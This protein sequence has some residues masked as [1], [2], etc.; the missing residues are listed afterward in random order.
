MRFFF[1]YLIILACFSQASAQDTAS[2][3]KADPAPFAELKKAFTAGSAKANREYKEEETV[4]Q[5][6]RVLEITRKLNQQ[7]KLLLKK[8][9]DTN[10]LHTFLD[11][12]RQSLDIVKEGIWVNAGTHQTQRNLA[13]SSAILVELST[14]IAQRKKLVDDYLEKLATIKVRIDSMGTDP[15]IYA[16]PSDSATLLKFVQRIYVA[17][18][19]ISPVDTAMN[20]TITSL[21]ALQLKTDLLEFEIRSAQEDIE[22]YSLELSQNTFKREF[23]DIWD[24]AANSR[25]L[26]QILEFSIA[27]EILLLE[28]YVENHQSLLIVLLIAVIGAWVFLRSLKQQLKEDKALNQNF[29]GQLVLR[30]PLLSA[31]LVVTIVL[32]FIF[33]SPPFIFSFCIW[34]LSASCLWLIFRGYITPYWLGFW[35][36]MSILFLFVGFDNLILQASRPERYVML[37]LSFVSVIYAGSILYTNRRTELKESKIRYAM[38]FLLVIH[39]L[40]FLFNIFGRF[41]ISK[42]LFIT[43]FAGAVTAIL[44]LWVLRLINEGLG[45]AVN[46]YKRPTSKFFYINFDKVGNRVPWL[47]YLLFTVGWS[48]IVSRNFYSF[49][50]FSEPFIQFLTADRTVGDYKYSISGMLIFVLV[51]LCSVVLSKLVSYFASEPDSPRHA[52]EVPKKGGL[53]SWILIVRIFIISLGL[54]FAFAAAGIP[55]DK[56]TIILGAL[57]VGIGL[58]LQGLVNN[59]IS[60]LIISFE[61]QINVGDTIEIDGKVATMKS[62]GFRTSIVNSSEGPNVIIPNGEL[63]SQP[64]INYSMGKNIK[65][66]SLLIGV[67]YD[68]DLEEVRREIKLILESDDRILEYPSSDAFFTEFG[69]SAIEVEVIY[70]AKNVKEY[71]S[72]RSDLITKIST[73]FKSKG[74]VIPFPQQD[75]NV[76]T[77]APNS[78]QSPPDNDSK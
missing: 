35:S 9:V 56:I 13:V 76:K 37:G 75:V 53:G 40:A 32:Q 20:K 14:R 38:L 52:G 25:P 61:R 51:L 8:P 78:K 63:L 39:V 28:F 26:D 54:F 17:A 50:R 64:M 68:S 23:P 41:N 65:K 22:I 12:T 74:I 24:A 66:C 30:Y 71:F 27:K 31:L 55:L 73:V 44:F 42:T 77:V 49:Q 16:F 29:S 43:G 62:I 1:I 69:P 10:S 67:A 45:L 2:A 21:E 48:V 47:F 15:S 4:N 70:W 59:L 46:A 6:R 33:P 60:G 57:S 5:Q 72:L 19:E 58:G 36:V 34:M 3:K 7:A 18:K 11:K